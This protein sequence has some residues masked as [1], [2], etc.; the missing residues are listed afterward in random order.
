MKGICNTGFRISN[1]N[2]L[3][4]LR[5]KKQWLGDVIAA[6]RYRK[7]HPDVGLD[8]E[9]VDANHYTE[10][11]NIMMA[12]DELPDIWLTKADLIP[13]LADE[14]LILPA[15]SFVQSDPEWKDAYKD[16]SPVSHPVSP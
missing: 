12:G 14:G 15:G 10:I 7:L 5:C 16:E 1:A 6:D 4:N 11:L 2:R 13:I 9:F 3:V 8:F